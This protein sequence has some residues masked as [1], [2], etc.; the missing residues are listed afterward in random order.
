MA[1]ADK[2]TS[3]YLISYNTCRTSGKQAFK[4]HG[5]NACLLTGTPL[6]GNLDTGASGTLHDEG[7][8]APGFHSEIT[9][10]LDGCLL[11]FGGLDSDRHFLGDP[12]HRFPDIS[13]RWPDPA[14]DFL[15]A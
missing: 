14:G 8:Q 7:S 13:E 12:A 5:C 4:I 6:Q 11:W 9:A 10:E 3:A 1:W 15:F 2:E